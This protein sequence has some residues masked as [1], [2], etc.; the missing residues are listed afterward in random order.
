MFPA[1]PDRAYCV[2]DKPGGQTISA[3]QFCFTGLAP[4]ERST[5]CKQF[6]ASSA[7]NRAIH[8]AAAEKC[9]V[10]SVHDDIHI[11]RRDVAADDI[12]LSCGILHFTGRG[13]RPANYRQPVACNGS[14][15]ANDWAV[16]A[17]IRLLRVLRGIRPSVTATE[18]AC[19]QTVLSSPPCARPIRGVHR[20]PRFDAMPT[21]SIGCRL[22]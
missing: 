4:A 16:P 12:D 2:N 7:M 6:G 8:S 14:D 19:R 3:G 9:R 22:V 17:R 21:R 20:A 10:R 18:W 11:E 13:V 5:F 15:R 1:C